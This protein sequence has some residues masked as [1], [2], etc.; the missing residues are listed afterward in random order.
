MS[1]NVQNSIR[2]LIS[3]AWSKHRCGQPTVARAT[4]EEGRVCLLHQASKET[5]LQ[6]GFEVA[7][8]PRVW[9][10][11]AQKECWFFFFFCGNESGHIKRPG[12]ALES[13]RATCGKVWMWNEL[14]LK[15]TV[16]AFTVWLA[17]PGFS[18]NVSCKKKNINANRKRHS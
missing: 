1:R 6:P 7:E 17:C 16:S 15:G 13:L 18:Q 5:D 3:L 8:T 12:P 14:L 11:G 10:V 2:G 9:T 4:S